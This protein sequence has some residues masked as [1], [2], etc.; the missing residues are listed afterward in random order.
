MS[1]FDEHS[2]GSASFPEA[3]VV[4]SGLSG[5]GKTTA[6]RAL[7]DAG[8]YC[9]D[10]LPAPLLTTFLRLTREHP[11][12]DRVAL[13]M[14]VREAF[15]DPGLPT[16]LDEVRSSGQQLRV[17]YLNCEDAQ[18]IHRFKSTRRRHPLIATGEAETL[19]EAIR[20]ER[21]WL[22]PIRAEAESV[23][24]TSSLTVH[25]LKRR[26]QGLFL[27]PG[28]GAMAVHLLSFGFGGG[29]PPEADYVF[30]VRFLPNP[31]FVEE[32]RDATGRNPT[33]ARYVFER[34]DATAVVD[35][36][37]G[38]LGDVLPLCEEE[39]KPSLT[40][41]VGCTGGQHRSVAVVERLR[42]QLEGRGRTATVRHRDLP[43]S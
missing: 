41:A 18:L 21:D 4:V 16:T 27:R 8:Y 39:G 1:T 32:L 10:N 15:Y 11:G 24:D 19:V 3:P 29:L 43:G 2:E 14:D 25:E 20:L 34:P 33:V 5:S 28:E 38:L 30:D 9:V 40:I 17:L 12:I 37:E 7:E 23:V 22:R 26:V 13:V 6:L 35:R 36:L 42:E 31:H